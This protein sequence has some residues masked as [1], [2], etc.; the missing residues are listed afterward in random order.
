[1]V[2]CQVLVTFSTFFNIAIGNYPEYL[3]NSG[4]AIV[5]GVVRVTNSV[6]KRMLLA[7]YNLIL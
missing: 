5:R 4:N 6:E 2:F 1:M 7:K 3:L